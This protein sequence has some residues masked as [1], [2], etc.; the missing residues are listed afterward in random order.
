MNLSIMPSITADGFNL[1]DLL[2]SVFSSEN[3]DSLMDQE[4]AQEP[5]VY[6]ASEDL[7]LSDLFSQSALQMFDSDSVLA[8]DGKVESE[9]P[10]QVVSLDSHDSSDEDMTA[11]LLSLLAVF[12]TPIQNIPLQQQ[13][14]SLGTSLDSDEKDTSQITLT[15]TGSLESLSWDQS[16]DFSLVQVDKKT[17]L[18]Q[19]PSKSKVVVDS[20]QFQTF[21]PNQNFIKKEENALNL[22]DIP[23][24]NLSTIYQPSR[25]MASSKMMSIKHGIDV[26]QVQKNEFISHVSE[27]LQTSIKENKNEVHV[28]LDPPEWGKMDIHL[29]MRPTHMDVSIRTEHAFVK[30]IFDQ[31]YI[32]LKNHLQNHGIFLGQLSVNVGDQSSQK[33]YQESERVYP[34]YE[35]ENQSPDI[36][37]IT[38]TLK[39]TPEGRVDHHV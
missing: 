27:V 30:E 26:E 32:D 37:P 18:I 19:S 35:E 10:P 34:L 17:T 2:P 11:S 38:I 33:F 31:N 20:V 21:V 39:K 22:P 12:P 14:I 6:E 13:S 16:S 1:L 4:L 8:L 23:M 25:E 5:E 28:Q 15:Q 9:A 24:M 3:F 7:Q 29:E 36:K